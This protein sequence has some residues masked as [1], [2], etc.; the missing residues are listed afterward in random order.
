MNNSFEINYIR[1]CLAL[2]ETRLN[3]GDSSQW[4]SYDFEKLSIAI[5]EATGVTL[6]VTTL[7]RLWGKLKYTNIPTT[8]TLNTLAKFAGYADWREFKRQ[9]SLD[10]ERGSMDERADSIMTPVA[11]E[12]NADTFAAPA[13]VTSSLPA[14]APVPAAIVTTRRKWPYWLLALLPTGILLYLLLISN[15]RPGSPVNP[16]H[17]SFSSNKIM[18]TGVPNS[19]IFSYNASAAGK[20]SVFIAQS[21]D[22]RRKIPVPPQEHTYSAIYYEPGYYRAKLMLGKQIVKEHDLMIASDGWLALL[23]NENGVPLYFKK[24][25]VAK[26]GE[27]TVDESLLSRYHISLQPAPPAL[28][29]FNVQDFGGIK[30]DHFIFE[31]TVKSNYHEGTAACQRLEILILCKNDLITIPLC[32]KG[33]VGDLGLYAAGAGARSRDADLSG[34]G[35]NLDEW[36]TLRVEAKDRHIRFLVNGK[37]AYALNFPNAPTDIVGLQYRFQGAGSVKDTRF[38]KDGKV[39]AL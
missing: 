30:N 23:E 8:T 25:E 22:I 9:V 38:I 39:I 31:T 26:N 5:E 36:V 20:D 12:Q 6:S 1:R 29:F 18:S 19:V 34:F 11:A 33:C 17:F 37:E 24:N 27:L 4:A 32:A 21:W 7:K 28:R 2:V 13:A 10:N 3:W 14:V 16:A 15:D 35:C